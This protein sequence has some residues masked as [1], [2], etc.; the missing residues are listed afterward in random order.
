MHLRTFF[1]DAPLEDRA[2]VW[3]PVAAVPASLSDPHIVMDGVVT[4][5]TVVTL[6][7]GDQLHVHMAT[8][9]P[10]GDVPDARHTA[11]EA[12]ELA[13]ALCAAADLLD[14]PR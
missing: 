5:Q 13:A 10:D 6:A 7:G 8:I 3:H 2:A 14:G 12:R 1:H 4:P 11:S 9:G